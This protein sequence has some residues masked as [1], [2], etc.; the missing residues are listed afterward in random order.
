MIPDDVRRFILAK[1][2]S[3]PH[4]EA[5]LLM[6]AQ[7][8]QERTA[9]EVAARLYVSERTAAELLSALCAAGILEG[10]DPPA[11]RY[12]HAPADAALEAVMDAVA[13]AYADD[14]VGVT[15][16]IHDATRKSAHRFAEAFRLRK[17][18]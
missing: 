5:A 17:E 8:D 14:L 1:I 9:A 15:R 10:T 13:R 18:K 7:P 4:L 6:H 11:A 2:P 3:V 12:R 16:L